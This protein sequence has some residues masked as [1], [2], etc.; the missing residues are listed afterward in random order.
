MATGITQVVFDDPEAVKV[1]WLSRLDKLVGEVEGWARA[2][3]WRTRRI[4]KTI[5]ERQ[6][7]EYKAPVLLMEKDAIEVV[8]NP[9]AR[10]VPGADGA[11]DLYLAPA[12]DDIASL[13]FEGD[14]WVV[15]RGKHPGPG[16]THGA[17]E[18]EPRP[19]DER[20]MAEILEGMSTGG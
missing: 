7:G 19:Y 17:L 4:Q 3:G 11:V 13:Y 8:L 12:Y 6:L 20:A 1:E 2:S 18:I 10:R 15:Y 14:R 9:V 16:E 5:N